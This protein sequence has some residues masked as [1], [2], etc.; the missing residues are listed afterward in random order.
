MTHN[1][2]YPDFTTDNFGS[3][4]SIDDNHIIIGAFGNITNSNISDTLYQAGAVYFYESSLA[5]L[6]NIT[7]QKSTIYGFENTLNIKIENENSAT[8]KIYDAIGSVV[9]SQDIKETESTINLNLSKGMYVVS[10]TN[11]G[12]IESKKVV[13]GE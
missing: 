12:F 9:Y 2:I 5:G 6:T 7:I 13:I 1:Y 10:L 11:N 4:I 8:L 3:T